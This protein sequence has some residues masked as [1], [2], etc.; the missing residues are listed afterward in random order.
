M[1]RNGAFGKGNDAPKAGALRPDI[2]CASSILEQGSTAT[3]KR[4]F[5]GTATRQIAPF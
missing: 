2:C 5:P 1:K 3:L 4:E